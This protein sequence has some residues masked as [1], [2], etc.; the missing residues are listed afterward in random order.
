MSHRNPSALPKTRAIRLRTTT[1]IHVSWDRLTEE[2]YIGAVPASNMMRM[3]LVIE[4]AHEDS[5]RWV[6]AA[7]GLPGALA[8]GDS[9]E[10]AIDAAETLA[11]RELSEHGVDGASE[12]LTMTVRAA[13]VTVPPP[14]LAPPR[15]PRSREPRVKRG[16]A[17]PVPVHRSRVARDR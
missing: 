2:H 10:E 12:L 15:P 17:R 16:S 6:A 11:L 4:I 8:Y 9:R 1:V 7:V 5:G 13:T 14:P 3:H